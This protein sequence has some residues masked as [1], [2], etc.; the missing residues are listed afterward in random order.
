MGSKPDTWMPLYI[1]AY[2][3]K[4]ARLTC[5]QHG[6]YLLLIMDYWVGGPLPD[7]DIALAQVTGLELRAWRKHRPV[8]QRFF[9]VAG[10]EWRH[11]RVEEE[12]EKAEHMAEARRVNGAKGGRPKKL[13]GT[14]HEPAGKPTTKPRDNRQ[15]NLEGTA[16]K[17]PT[18][19]A[20]HTSPLPDDAS[21]SSPPVV[22][23]DELADA[24]EAYNVVAGELGLPI[25]KTLTPDRRR[26]M[27]ARLSEH[28]FDG[29]RKAMEGLRAP[30]CCGE[31]DR[32]WRAN[33]DFAL[34]AKSCAKLV[35]DAFAGEARGPPVT[36]GMLA[37][38]SDEAGF[39][40][41][42]QRARERDQD[43]GNSL[44]D[45]GSGVAL[46]APSTGP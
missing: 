33:L 2:R 40:L 20:R 37:A 34:Q 18:R 38:A 13:N 25:A 41:A 9:T 42:M 36:G 23:R 45:Q 11:D 1:A 21:A 16:D 24:L 43:R 19:V 27:R 14:G 39:R 7:D 29:W 5:E 6:A 30:F 12:R 22:P 31:N 10:G 3:K 4:T 8:L 46:P 28:G 17:T 26:Q 35:E 15:D 32:G 44:R